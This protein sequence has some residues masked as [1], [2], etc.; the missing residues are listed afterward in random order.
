MIITIDGPAAAGKGTL[1]AA[2]S[3]H[4]RLAYFDTG[5]IYRAVGLEMVLS[6][7]CVED[8]EKALETAKKMT[9]ERMMELSAHKDFRSD[10]GGQAASKVSA[11][12]SVRQ[13]LLKMQQDFSLSPT[14]ADGTPANGAVYDGRDTGTVVCP[15]AD[16][17]F[18]VTASLEVRA[19]R[20]FKEFVAKGIETT[21]EK[22]L[23]DMITRDKRDSERA[24]APL[25]P[26]KDAIIVDTSEMDEQTEIQTVIDV[27]E[28]KIFSTKKL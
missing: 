11:I 17:K 12:G 2:L 8:E 23:E 19:M 18:F 14:F 25:K 22:V 4:Y 7:F 15:N 1:A 10:I 26:A 27:I 9:F 5:M 3:K 6:G 13:A 20:R 28:Q 16:I 24:A 21:Y